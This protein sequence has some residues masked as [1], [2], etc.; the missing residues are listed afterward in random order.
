M[1]TVSL[2]DLQQFFQNPAK[3][4]VERRLEFRLPEDQEFLSDEEPFFVTGLD[5]FNFKQEIV[6]AFLDRRPSDKILSAWKGGGHLP[7]GP[8]GVWKPT[9]WLRK[10]SRS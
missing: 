1:E 9:T 2:K 5:A 8:T 7:P 6:E 10:P 3:F 4:F